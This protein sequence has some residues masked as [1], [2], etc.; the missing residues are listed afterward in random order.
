MFRMELPRETIDRVSQYWQDWA[1]QPVSN[2]VS[3][4][5]IGRQHFV[6][7]PEPLRGRLGENPPTDLDGLLHLL[8]GEVSEV[9]GEACLAYADAVTLRLAST[10]GV[11]DIAADDARVAAFQAVSDRNEWLEASV[12]ASDHRF[13]VV[14]DDVLVAVA[15]VQVWTDRIGHLRVFAAPAARG[16]GLASKAA[17]GAIDLAVGRGLVPQWRSRR[18]NR[19]SARV[20]DKLGFVSV[21][22]QTYVR[23]K[24]TT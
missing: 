5:T 1:A 10:D 8:S 16:R 19:V 4:V 24:T 15:G 22:T 21:G 23:V 3:V 6:S 13:G 2:A 7:A 20:A 12:E 14:E 9:I 17:S 11:I 18:E